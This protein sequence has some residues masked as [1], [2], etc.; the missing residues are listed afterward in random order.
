MNKWWLCL[1]VVPAL[2]VVGCQRG[3]FSEQAQSGAANVFRYPMN[4]KPTSLDPHTVQDGD[5]IDL[6]Q[7]VFEGLVG[8]DENNEVVGL[9]AEKWEVSP[10]GKVYTFTLKDAKFHNGK[11]VTAEDVKWSLERAASPALKSTTTGAYLSDIQGMT[12]M[13]AGKAPNLTGVKVID[14][15]TVEI[16]LTEPLPTF[17]GK[18]TYL[19]SAVMPKDS[20]GPSEITKPEQMIGTG[21]FK[22]AQYLPD[23]L[24]VLEANKDYHRGAPKLAKIE[25]PIILD[26]Q[27]RLNKFQAGE[28]DLISLPRQDAAALAKD[29]KFKNQLKSFDRAA[30]WYI[31]MN[32]MQ[33]APFKDRRVRQAFAM[34][35]DRE[36]IVRDQLGGLVPIANSIVPKGIK[37]GG[38]QGKVHPYNPEKARQLLAEAGFANGQGMPPLNMTFREWPDAPAITEAIASQIKQN[39]NVEVKIQRTE[40]GAYLQ[41]YNEGKQVFYHM[42]WG[43]DF[44]DPQNFLSHMLTTKGPENKFGYSNPTYDELCARADRLLKWEERLPLYAQAEDIVLQDAPWVP[45]YYQVDY[46]LHHPGLTGLRKSLFGHLPHLNTEIKR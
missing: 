34:A 32:Q 19:T 6:L 20:V 36:R 18:F 35:I 29:E 16:T 38:R 27:T 5:T 14:P 11:T 22:V 23:Q 44:L 45:L 30:L 41:A 31:G 8:W 26:S 39:L 15:K 33:Y 10:D 43:A 2:F 42:R 12:E 13:L 28:V 21:P 7:N 17:I 25:R 3:N 24:V 40:L 4:V 37:G 46:E 9:L 1:L